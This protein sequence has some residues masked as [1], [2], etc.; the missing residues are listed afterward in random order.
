[1]PAEKCSVKYPDFCEAIIRCLQEGAN[2]SC[3]KSDMASAFRHFP[4]SKKSWR[5]LVMKARSPIDHKWYFF[6][7]KCMPFGS[8]ISCAHFQALS[9]AIAF[10]QWKCSGKKPVNYLDDFLFIHLLKYLCD[11]QVDIFLSICDQIKFPVSMEKTFW[12]AQVITFLG[13][14][15]DTVK[16]IVSIPK[17]KN[18]KGNSPVKQNSQQQKEKSYSSSDPENMWFAEFFLQEYSTRQAF[19]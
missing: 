9:N 4:M 14:L 5:Y 16:Q 12:G 3:A 10:V 19:Y 18:S 15:I 1:M 17:D 2:C 11:R 7:D 13:M 6:I 8:S